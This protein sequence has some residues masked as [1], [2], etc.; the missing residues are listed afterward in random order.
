MVKLASGALGSGEYISHKPR[1]Y[2]LCSS[3]NP[4]SAVDNSLTNLSPSAYLDLTKAYIG[5]FSRAFTLGLL[6]NLLKFFSLEKMELS[7]K[8]SIYAS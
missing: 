2:V 7:Y 6:M 8:L 3:S 5:S 1:T 4:L